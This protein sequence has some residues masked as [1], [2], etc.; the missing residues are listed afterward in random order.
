MYVR[1]QI[2]KDNSMFDK[3][4][5]LLFHGNDPRPRKRSTRPT[6]QMKLQNGGSNPTNQEETDL[7]FLHKC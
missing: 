4:E 3:W 6:W 2:S 5:N 7:W 1:W